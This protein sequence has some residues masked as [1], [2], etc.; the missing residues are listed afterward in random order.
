MA[1]YNVLCDL[2]CFCVTMARTYMWI[3]QTAHLSIIRIP[4]S[5][6]I[7]LYKLVILRYTDS[8]YIRFVFSWRG[9]VYAGS[10]V[11]MHAMLVHEKYVLHDINI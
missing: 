10:V 8:D 6:I 5:F 7:K 1:S 4:I 3:L 2:C 11:D 9:L